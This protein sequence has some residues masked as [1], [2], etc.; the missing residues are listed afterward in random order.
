VSGYSYFYYHVYFQ[1]CVPG[2]ELAERDEWGKFTVF[3]L[4][5]VRLKEPMGHSSMLEQW[6]TRNGELR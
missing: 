5:P 1:G 3:C 6:E 4:G 2:E